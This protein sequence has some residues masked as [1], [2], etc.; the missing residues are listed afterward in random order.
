MQFNF[1]SYLLCLALATI[2]FWALPS[3][4]RRGYVLALSLTF[5]ATWNL[6]LVVIPF[7]LCTITFLCA[8]VIRANKGQPPAHRS[9]RRSRRLRNRDFRRR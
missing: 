5:Y 7:I 3:R 8:R 1:Y 4:F 9:G 6:Y 2:V